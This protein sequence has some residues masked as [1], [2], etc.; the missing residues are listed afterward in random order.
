[1]MYNP[2]TPP[3]TIS[4]QTQNICYPSPIE[5]ENKITSGANSMTTT[6]VS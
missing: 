4:E 2:G 5:L 3:E 6:R 1:M